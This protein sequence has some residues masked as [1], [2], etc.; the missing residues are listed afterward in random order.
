MSGCRFG[1]LAFGDDPGP[2]R[3]LAMHS[4]LTGE[5]DEEIRAAT[6][7]GIVLEGWGGDDAADGDDNQHLA[8]CGSE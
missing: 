5:G 6:A 3:E 8:G 7:D 4:W 1:G 2:M